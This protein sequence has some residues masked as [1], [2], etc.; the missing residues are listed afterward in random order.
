MER[1]ALKLYEKHANRPEGS[2]L[3]FHDL[4]HA[5]ELSEPRVLCRVTYGRRR[6]QLLAH[7]FTTFPGLTDS[8]S[9][10][11]ES[12]CG[13]EPRRQT[14]HTRSP[15][16]ISGPGRPHH[17]QRITR[18]LA[19]SMCIRFDCNG[20]LI[21]SSAKNISRCFLGPHE[22]KFCRGSTR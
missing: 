16:K 18:P 4:A 19:S 15:A 17:P 8:R 9:V 7:L 10:F 5:P 14:H 11:C 6:G 21:S 13:L 2:Y 20:S 22:A 3:T 12:K 1:T